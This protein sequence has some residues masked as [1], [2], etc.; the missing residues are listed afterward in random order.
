MQA[1]YPLNQVSDVTSSAICVI[2]VFEVSFKALA[3]YLIE[4]QRENACCSVRS[5]DRYET[6]LFSLMT[7]G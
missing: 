2:R 5:R 1:I 7:L 3:R 4:K 6:A